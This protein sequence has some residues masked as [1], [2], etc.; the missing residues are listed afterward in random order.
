[1]ARI[2]VGEG[3]TRALV[4]H[5]NDLCG[6]LYVPLAEA[7][8]RRGVACTLVT[9]PGFAG[10]PPL[11]SPSWAALVDVLEELCQELRPT[12]LVGHS[13]GGLLT[14]L[15]AARRPTSVRALALLEPAIFPGPFVARIAARRYLKRVVRAP[16][17]RDDAFQNDN[18]GQRRLA[19]PERFP[20]SLFALHREARR[21]SDAGT[22]EALFTSLPALWPLP[23]AAV[24]VPVLLVRGARSGVLSR[25]QTADLARRFRSRPVVMKDAAHW[26]LGEADEAVAEA[27]ASFARTHEQP[28]PST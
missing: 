26:L 19:H 13:M 27:V 8:A 24:S 20:P 1:M 11:L 5:G 6:K 15:L 21:T 3:N 18:G 16:R 4:V 9:L 28:P 17:D 7:L 2:D 23:F 22:A 10:E 14:L 25:V 12:L